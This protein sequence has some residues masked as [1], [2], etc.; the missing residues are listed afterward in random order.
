MSKRVD[1]AMELRNELRQLIANSDICSQREIQIRHDLQELLANL[2]WN[3][4]ELYLARFER[5]HM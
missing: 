1:K 5:L 4:V 3:E 2:T